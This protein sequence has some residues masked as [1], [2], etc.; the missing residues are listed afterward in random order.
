MNYGDTDVHVASARLQN[1]IKRL[2]G[3]P[4]EQLVFEFKSSGGLMKLN[5]VTINPRHEQ[6][7]LFHSTTGVNEPD[8]L[9]KMFKYVREERRLENSFT[10]QWSRES[11]NELHTSY[12]RARNI[13]EAL[14]KF[15]YGRD[16]NST[17][18]Y[19]V[20]LNPIS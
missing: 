9:E 14:D 20:V 3:L 18:V 5:L 11:E 4:D 16:M 15:Y 2:L 19:S 12:F 8:A 17:L 10:I 13:M 1:E 7:F 6:S